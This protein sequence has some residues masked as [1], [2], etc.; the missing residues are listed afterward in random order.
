M[1][2]KKMYYDTGELKR[3]FVYIRENDLNNFYVKEYFKNGHI[4]EEGH[5]KN[6]SLPDGLWK[7]YYA[8][9]ELLWEGEM[10]DGTIQDE[11]LWRW[12]E[13]PDCFQNIEFN[14]DPEKFI[15]GKSYKFRIIMTKVHP[16]FYKAVDINNNDLSNKDA[17][18]EMY[19]YIFTYVPD[20]EGKYIIKIIF[21][22]KSKYFLKSA[23]YIEYSLLDVNMKTADSR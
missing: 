4:K 5:I 10:M 17:D 23:P 3:E 2:V 7:Y 12:K 19:P 18:S 16:R 1:E 14:E 8:D 21:K 9:G 22:D 13:C 15:V 11:Y 6:D 20:K